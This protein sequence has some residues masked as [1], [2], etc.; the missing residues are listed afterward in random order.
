MPFPFRRRFFYWDIDDEI[1]RIEKE[2]EEML[3]SLAEMDESLREFLKEDKEKFITKEPF[4]YGFS[5]RIGK[6]GVPIIRKF[7]NVNVKDVLKEKT[8]GVKIKPEDLVYMRE[9]LIDVIEDDNN[10]TVIAEVPGVDK[11]DIKLTTTEENLTI[12]VDTEKRKYHKTINL[13]AE[14]IPETAKATYKNGILEVKLEKKKK[15]EGK[16]GVNIKIE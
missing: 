4:V 5:I 12:D 8:E 11:N 6:D 15:K 13:P 3:E 9:P 1:R 2:I 10:I 7:G 14:I 16:E